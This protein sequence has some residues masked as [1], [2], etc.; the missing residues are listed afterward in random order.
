M[1]DSAIEPFSPK[2]REFS[3]DVPVKALDT[4]DGAHNFA[5]SEYGDEGEGY[6]LE[7]MAAFLIAEGWTPPPEDD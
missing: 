6:D 5:R 2:A 1:I 7:L 4:V 3:K